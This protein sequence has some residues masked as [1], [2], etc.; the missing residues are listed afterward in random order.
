[1][2]DEINNNAQIPAELVALAG[3]RRFFAFK[4]VFSGEYSGVRGACLIIIDEKAIRVD[5][6]YVIIAGEG[7]D[8]KYQTQQD[9]KSF[10]SN[11]ISTK[12][13]GKIAHQTTIDVQSYLKKTLQDDLLLSLLDAGRGNLINDVRRIIADLISKA[14]ADSQILLQI[15]IETFEESGEGGEVISSEQGVFVAAADGAGTGT[16]VS[17]PQELIRLRVEPLLSPVQGVAAKN[18]LPGMTIHVEIKDPSTIKQ[19]ITKMLIFKPGSGGR[20]NVLEA[21]VLSIQPAEYERVTIIT[22]LA[23]NVQGISTISGELRIKVSETAK[24]FYDVISSGTSLPTGPAL[25]SRAFFWSL[26]GII[27]IMLIMAY[28]IFGGIISV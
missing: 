8:F 10:E 5:R 4:G 14:I 13:Q 16:V 17:Q 1:M 23:S 22:Q 2:S 27:V 26:F 19:H 3:K 11:I 12:L 20:N 24:K 25:S 18:L 9:W 15:E 28:L 7:D 6:L 21:R